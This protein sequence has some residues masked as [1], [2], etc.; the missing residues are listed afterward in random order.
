MRIRYF[1]RTYIIIFSV[2]GLL[3]DVLS[4]C[5]VKNDVYLALSDRNTETVTRR[6]EG[7]S[8][9]P[10]LI[11]MAEHE[12]HD[13]QSFSNFSDTMQQIDQSHEVLYAQ[14]RH[15]PEAATPKC[16][17][18][19]CRINVPHVSQCPQYHRQVIYRVYHLLS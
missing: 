4:I 5:K 18:I 11:N 12:A 1:P 6:C 13:A 9:P 17:K 8:I 19:K 10:T 3:N 16:R 2:F 15:C 7:V 14:D